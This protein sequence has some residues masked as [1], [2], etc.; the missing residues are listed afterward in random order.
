M[1]LLLEYSKIADVS[2]PLSILAVV[3]TLA[4]MLIVVHSLPSSQKSVVLQFS[5]NQAWAASLALGR[6]GWRRGTLNR[7][8]D[9]TI[10][11]IIIHIH[12]YNYVHIYVSFSNSN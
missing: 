8:I 3:V 11:V 9:I 7:M 5:A 2:L 6:V 10:R 1:Y 12:L 4:H